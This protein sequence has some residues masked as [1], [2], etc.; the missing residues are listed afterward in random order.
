MD[1]GGEGID[2][3]LLMCLSPAA[4]VKRAR[5]MMVVKFEEIERGRVVYWKA[6]LPL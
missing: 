4:A 3:V 2:A 1:G 6:M 5:A